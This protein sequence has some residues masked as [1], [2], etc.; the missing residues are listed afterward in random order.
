M[1]NLLTERVEFRRWR[2]KLGKQWWI[3]AIFGTTYYNTHRGPGFMLQGLHVCCSLFLLTTLWAGLVVYSLSTSGTLMLWGSS[4]QTGSLAE[5]GSWCLISA[6]CSSTYQL[7]SHTM[8]LP[9]VV[10][11]C[12]DHW[13][14]FFLL[15]IIKWGLSMGQQTWENY[16]TVSRKSK[17]LGPKG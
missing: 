16:T 5:W 8:L 15:F 10:Q 1:Q 6:L 17:H 3:K 7:L 13:A 14:N 12:Q 2:E 4:T 11:I 9:L